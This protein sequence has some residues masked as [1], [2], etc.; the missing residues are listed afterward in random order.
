MSTAQAGSARRIPRIELLP[1]AEALEYAHRLG[2]TGRKDWQT[3][4]KSGQ[5][6]S[7]VPGNP[8]KSPS[9]Q[10]RPHPRDITTKY[11]IHQAALELRLA[12]PAAAGARYAED[13][14]AQGGK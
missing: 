10:P 14:A 1:F 4:C 9:P 12:D 11:Q 5:R 8:S 2:F 6:P 13:W 7:N 3:W